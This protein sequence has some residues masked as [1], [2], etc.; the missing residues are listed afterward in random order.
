[1]QP[2]KDI[3][4][5][6]LKT[7]EN[8]EE[9][10]RRIHQDK[11]DYSECIYLN[12]HNK[13]KIYC[14]VHNTYFEKSTANHLA[15][16]GCPTCAEDT[17][18]MR[19]NKGLIK[20]IEEANT[21]YNNKYDYSIVEYKNCK[22]KVCIICPEHGEFY[23]IPNTHLRGTHGCPKCANRIKGI[24]KRTTIYEFIE[25]CT[26]IHHNKY[27]YS[28]VTYINSDSKVCIICPEHGQFY[29]TPRDHL[30]NGTGCPKCA[31]STSSKA[32]AHNIN[33]FITKSKEIHKDKYDYS[34]SEYIN[35]H[36]NLK[37]ICPEHGEFYQTPATHIRKSGCPECGNLNSRK[38]YINRKT[39]I[40]YI[41]L[42][43]EDKTWYKIGITS[44]ST[45][46]KRF[47][48]ESHLNIEVIN[49]K[50]F[51]SGKPAY[52]LEQEILKEFDSYKTQDKPLNKGGN[53]EVF[54]KD[55][56][57][58]IKHHFQ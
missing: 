9:K 19:K 39:T 3:S 41:K 58:H 20:F 7:F 6:A 22:T 35:N 36:T 26:N 47:S 34:N 30:N 33:L 43:L 29:Q 12:F 18:P 17:R 45:I 57:Q 50:V 27:D 13:M 1:M 14:N 52:E 56:Y 25:K 49:T 54:D 32:R 53:S 4:K 37:I 5:R 16:Q 15:G 40:Y 42:T 46:F 55:I 23:Q 8:L 48:A 2:H 38:R 11:F 31:I 21:K 10:F 28:E 44:K 24:N 51:E